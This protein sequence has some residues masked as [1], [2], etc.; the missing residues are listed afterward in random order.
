MTG[1]GVEPATASGT[2]AMEAEFDTVAGWTEAAVAALGDDYAIPA[3]CRGSGSPAALDWLAEA[4]ELGQGVRFL[5]AGAGLGGPAAWL[6]D[7]YGVQSVLA[8]PMGHA[9]AGSRRL[10]G[11]P[12]VLAWS[13]QLPFATASFDAGWALGVLCTTNR[14]LE[15]LTELRRVLVPTG[16]LGLLVYVA[17]TDPLPDCPEGNFFPTPDELGRGVEEAGFLVIQQIDGSGLPGAPVGWQ[18]RVD[19][20]EDEITGRHHRDQRWQE[21]RTQERRLGSLLRLGHVRPQL[22]HAVAS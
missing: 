6:A 7:R 10:F 18:A 19:R 9:A 13:Q 16:R 3:A 8:E 14:K 5:D 1:D 11:L 15:L 20:V 22:L 21:A 4:L 2:T 12:S 17:E